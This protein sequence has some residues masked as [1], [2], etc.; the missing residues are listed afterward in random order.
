MCELGAMLEDRRKRDSLVSDAGL[1]IPSYTDRPSGLKVCTSMAR[2][3]VRLSVRSIA[4]PLLRGSLS[5]FS[6]PR[7]AIQ[8]DLPRLWEI[9]LAA[10]WY[11]KDIEHDSKVPDNAYELL[12]DRIFP[13]AESAKL[14][15]AQT[16]VWSISPSDGSASDAIAGFY[17]LHIPTDKPSSPTDIN[18]FC[19][20]ASFGAKDLGHSMLHHIFLNNPTKDLTVTTWQGNKRARAFYARNGFE[21]QEISEKEVADANAESRP[22]KVELRKK[23]KHPLELHTW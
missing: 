13:R 5:S 1:C 2:Q 8:D 20:D 14:Y 15:Q 21:E 16:I 7:A 10:I 23:R 9:Y 19:T 6:Q 11:N 18:L 17:T 4:V 22:V 12:K 3:D